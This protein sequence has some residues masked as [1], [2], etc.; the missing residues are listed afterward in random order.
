MEA[1]FFLK[2]KIKPEFSSIQEIWNVLFDAILYVTKTDIRFTLRINTPKRIFGPQES[3][4]TSYRLFFDVISFTPDANY[5]IVKK[6]IFSEESIRGHSTTDSGSSIDIKF[7]S[8]EFEIEN[9]YSTEDEIFCMYYGNVI[10]YNDF[11]KEYHLDPTLK[12][13][14]KLE[15]RT[16]PF[17]V[18]NSK[19]SIRPEIYVNIKDKTKE[20]VFG[21]ESFINIK[22]DLDVDATI[23]CVNVLDLIF[24]FYYRKMIQCNFIKYLVNRKG[25]IVYKISDNVENERCPTYHLGMQN[26]FML[27][28]NINFEI[29]QSNYETFF[30]II[31]LY[32]NASYSKD[33][34]SKF[35]LHFL[36][37][38]L[39][40]AKF[41]NEERS[42]FIF[43][44]INLKNRIRTFLIDLANYLS[45]Q[46]KES[47]TLNE[48]QREDNL[49]TEKEMLT[50][51]SKVGYLED[52]II[53]KAMSHQFK[54]LM[55]IYPMDLS[56][57]GVDLRILT[58]LRGKIFHGSTLKPIDETNLKEICVRE[59]L[60]KFITELIVRVMGG[61]PENYNRN[62]Y[63][64]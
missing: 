38:E 12:P 47:K 33:N 61:N 23:H 43:K 29:I 58:K 25:K 63:D 50:C 60:P 6:I 54:R 49:T 19:I 32:I 52:T 4:Q 62:I 5:T 40:K 10:S 1:T 11:Y 24:S 21:K 22:C 27:L 55:D 39:L 41:G 34:K 51:P 15:R 48:K 44:N 30:D 45:L 28:Y 9:Q 20:T 64:G 18:L 36:A 7:N 59:R 17:H 35:I 31:N 26:K 13:T 57:Y 2:I 46:E 16:E 37:L 42:N 56:K 14:F 3:F 8:I 53:L